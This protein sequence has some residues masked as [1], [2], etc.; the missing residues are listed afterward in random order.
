MVDLAVVE[1]DVRVDVARHA[2]GALPD[3]RSDLGPG[4]PL[5]MQERDPAVPQVVWREQRDPKALHDFAI[6][7]QSASAPGLREQPCRRVAI[8][9]RYE[10][11]L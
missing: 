9:A 10:R 1:Q 5:P 3:E 2:R 4:A 8:L 6:A 7:V 11:G